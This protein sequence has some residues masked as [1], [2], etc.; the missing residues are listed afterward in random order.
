MDKLSVTNRLI[1]FSVIILIITMMTSGMMPGMNAIAQSNSTSNATLSPYT[2][3]VDKRMQEILS[4]D[5]PKDIATLAYVYG[6][7]LVSVVRTEDFTT[8]PNIPAGPG[9]G[10]V[11]TFNAFRDFPNSSFTDI[12][13]PNVDT[14]YSTGY[15]DLSKEPLVLEFPPIEDRYYSLQFID[16]YSNNFLYLGSRENVTTGGTYLITGPGWNGTLPSGMKEIKAPTNIGLIAVRIFVN[17]FDD[18]STVHSLQDKFTLSTLSSFKGEGSSTTPVAETNSNASKEIPLSPDPTLIPKS[19]IAIYDEISND[20][21]KNIPLQADSSVLAKFKLIGVGPGL[22][23]S[24]AAN[25]TIKQA[26]ETGIINGEQLIDQKIQ[27]L[28]TVVNG[29]SIPGLVMKDGKG[30]FDIGNFGT[31]YLLRAGVA[32]FGLF[33][34]SAEEAVYPTTFKDSQGQNLTGMQNY[35]IHFDKGQT[36]PVRAFWSVTLYNN[37]SHLA[38]NPIDRYSIASHTPGLKYNDDESL[39]IY[40]QHDN[41]GTDKESNWLPSPSGDFSL[42]MRFYVPEEPI[43]TGKYQLPPLQ[44]V[45]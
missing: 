34:N 6:F 25:D 20:M 21:A 17:G 40:I 33:A 41:P 10:P 15:F 19:G 24:Q 13:S 16:A 8:S 31:N 9:R 32:K 4:S 11:N 45:S 2:T 1:L 22:T 28:G 36:P 42:S 7:P 30:K 5:D 14:L 43:L 3:D 29:W 12:V 38:D 39:D 35:V 23:P 27:N 18:V 26:L 37:E 44:L